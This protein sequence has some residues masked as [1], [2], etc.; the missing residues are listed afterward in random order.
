MP[1]HM[2]RYS[3][4][5]QVFEYH[6]T[7]SECGGI[8]LRYKIRTGSFPLEFETSDIAVYRSHVFGERGERIFEQEN[9]A[10]YDPL[11]FEFTDPTAEYGQVYYYALLQ[12][13]DWGAQG[14]AHVV[15]N[16]MGQMRVDTSEVLDV[17]EPVVEIE[18]PIVEVGEPE[19]VPEPVPELEP[20]EILQYEETPR[21]RLAIYIAIFLV[22]GFVIFVAIGAGKRGGK[23]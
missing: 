8:T 7:P 15:D 3:W 2:V 4:A 11:L 9:V 14:F 16:W 22:A 1:H 21:S 5:R 18:V 20:V 6:A 19:P 10:F 23:R 12:I 17:P 13:T